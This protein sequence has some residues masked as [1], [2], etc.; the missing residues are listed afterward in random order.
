MRVQGSG[1]IV[2]GL[3]FGVPGSG[4]RGFE[5]RVSCLGCGV[6]GGLACTRRRGPWTGAINCKALCGSNLVMLPP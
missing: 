5:V 6:W 4:F 2:W 1:L 3:E